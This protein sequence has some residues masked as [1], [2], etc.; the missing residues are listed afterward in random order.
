LKKK[1]KKTTTKTCASLSILVFLGISVMN[2]GDL[3]FAWH[4]ACFAV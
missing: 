4:H 1:K 2:V 3:D